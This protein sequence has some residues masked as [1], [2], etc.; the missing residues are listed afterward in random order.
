M[1]SVFCVMAIIIVAVWQGSAIGENPNDS[2][3]ESN[4]RNTGVR[5]YGSLDQNCQ[6]NKPPVVEIT[7]QPTHGIATVQLGQSEVASASG[8]LE[9]CTGRTIVA[10]WVVYAPSVGFQGTDRLVL[11]VRYLHGRVN[12]E[13]VVIAVK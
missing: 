11:T 3:V 12:R 7:S 1:R 10:T 2:T 13:V 5:R 8:S 9:A 6:N 4:G